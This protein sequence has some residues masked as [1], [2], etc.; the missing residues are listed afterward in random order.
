MGILKKQTNKS[1]I[2]SLWVS[3][4]V[5]NSLI[6]RFNQKLLRFLFP[7]WDFCCLQ[8]P[9]CLVLGIA[10]YVATL[11]YMRDLDL[12]QNTLLQLC[13]FPG[14]MYIV[15]G[16]GLLGEQSYTLEK[17]FLLDTIKPWT[18]GLTSQQDS[19]CRCWSFHLHNQ[20]LVWF[21]AKG[22]MLSVQEQISL[23]WQAITA[24]LVITHMRNSFP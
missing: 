8:Y 12:S 15:P 4:V 17:K 2:V 9:G 19:T 16:C 10:L 3:K 14:L 7:W 22:K 24:R 1:R 6:R 20:W 21:K 5:H 23:E 11:Y 13:I 18:L